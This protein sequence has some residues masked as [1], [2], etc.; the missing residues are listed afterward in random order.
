MVMEG[1]GMDDAIE[2][3]LSAASLRRELTAAKKTIAELRAADLYQQ[4]L[5]RKELAASRQTVGRWQAKWADEHDALLTVEEK[6]RMHQIGSCKLIAEI[7]GASPLRESD[8]MPEV[9]QRVRDLQYRIKV[10][11]LE[12]EDLQLKAQGKFD[13]GYTFK[14]HRHTLP[15]DVKP[16]DAFAVTLV[17]VAGHDRDWACYAGQAG[18]LP[19]QIAAHGDK[20]AEKQAGLFAHVMQRRYYR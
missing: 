9:R 18:W 3:L 5:Y 16:N 8:T 10:L 11:L 1:M 4:K 20:V 7:E 17:A 12:K 2:C 13:G 19:A 15:E 6:L 14:N